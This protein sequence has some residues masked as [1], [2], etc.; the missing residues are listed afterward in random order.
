M[1][2][3]KS[4]GDDNLMS[5]EI[6]GNSSIGVCVNVTRESHRKERTPMQGKEQ[7]GNKINECTLKTSMS[8]D[9]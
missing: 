8:K 1:R 9:M 4:V 3:D 5:D 7:E 2:D 6:E